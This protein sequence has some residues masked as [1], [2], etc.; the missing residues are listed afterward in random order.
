MENLGLLLFKSA[1]WLTGFALVYLLLLRNER[2][3]RLNRIFLLTGIVASLLFPF[4][5]FHYNVVAPSNLTESASVGLLSEGVVVPDEPAAL[6]VYFWI[7]L[8]GIVAFL[9]RLLFQTWRIIRKLRKSGYEQAGIV[10]LVRTAE[11]A[12]SF[13]FFSFVFVNP[14]TANIEMEEIINHEREHIQQRHWFDLLLV[15]LICIV[16]WFNPFA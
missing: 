2:Y 15:E 9:L 8:V 1:A 10:K 6:P 7:Y 5:T 3:F 4:Y 11:Y 12:S 16:Q 13:S 14:S